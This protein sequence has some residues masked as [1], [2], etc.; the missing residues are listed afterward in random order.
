VAGHRIRIDLGAAEGAD[1]VRRLAEDEAFYNTFKANPK[2][3][4]AEHDIV[5][6]GPMAPTAADVP[7]QSEIQ[8]LVA[9]ADQGTGLVAGAL[10]PAGHPIF[11]VLFAFPFSHEDSE[12][13]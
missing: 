8:D 3:V 6:S 9:A 7:P 11:K 12:E 13:D 5:V 10:E 2:A 4:L 1:L